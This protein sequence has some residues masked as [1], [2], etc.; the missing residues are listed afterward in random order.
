MS[1]DQEVDRQ[2][3]QNR[4]VTI[5]DCVQ[6]SGHVLRFRLVSSVGSQPGHE[7]FVD[8]TAGDAWLLLHQVGDG[9]ETV[10]VFRLES[11]V[12]ECESGANVSWEFERE[13][14]R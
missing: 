13:L 14:T 11:Q 6:E 3:G 9:G 12:D 4:L 5:E 1:D 10:R 2:I 7:A 8:D